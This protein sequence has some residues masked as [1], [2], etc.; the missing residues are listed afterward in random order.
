MKIVG[1]AL[2]EGEKFSW[3][4]LFCVVKRGFVEP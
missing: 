4:S 1:A 2:E 3:L